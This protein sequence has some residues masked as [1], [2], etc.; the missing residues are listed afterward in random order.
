MY[1][2]ALVIMLL[3]GSP[4]WAEEP[5]KIIS[6]PLKTVAL[7]D[8]QG[9]FQGDIASD[10]MPVPEVS[11]LGFDEERNLI[12]I[13]LAGRQV[14]LDPLDVKLNRGKTVEASCRKV[15]ET[16]VRADK[17]VKAVMGYSQDCG[18]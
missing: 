9:E 3:S 6:Y 14:W 2:V 18:K 17:K 7:Y 1:K 16:S 15:A 8:A 10:Q 5:L 13:A 12:Q 4:A 11:V